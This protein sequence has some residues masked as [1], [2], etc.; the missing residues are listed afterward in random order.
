ML[1]IGACRSS[2]SICLYVC[3]YVYLY[4]LH[5]YIYYTHTYAYHMPLM[6]S[7]KTGSEGSHSQL[8]LRGPTHHKTLGLNSARFKPKSILLLT[9]EAFERCRARKMFTRGPFLKT[10]AVHVSQDAS[11]VGRRAAPANQ[12]QCWIIPTRTMKVFAC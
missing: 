2:S 10:S 3:R 4:N 11:R 12:N 1:C 5:I 9:G 8:C 7:Q 6:L